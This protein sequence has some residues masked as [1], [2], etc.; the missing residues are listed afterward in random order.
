LSKWEFTPATRGGVPVDVDVMVEIPFKLAP[1][2][3]AP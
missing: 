3:P 2:I 1:R